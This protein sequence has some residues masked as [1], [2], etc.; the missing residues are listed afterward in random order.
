MYEL[1]R[2]MKRL[3]IYCANRKTYLHKLE[4][5]LKYSIRIQKSNSHLAVGKHIFDK[6]V[7]WIMYILNGNRFDHHHASKNPNLIVGKFEFI[8]FW[9]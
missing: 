9:L 7:M 1:I 5:L 8:F 3:K 6:F 2:P 4:K